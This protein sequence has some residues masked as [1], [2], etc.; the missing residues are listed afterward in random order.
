MSG[1]STTPLPCPTC[2]AAPRVDAGLRWIVACIDCFDAELNDRHVHITSPYGFGQDRDS[3]V[4]R[5]N[6]AVERANTI[7]FL[8]RLT[9]EATGDLC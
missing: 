8:S 3:A 9:P 7:A 2:G 4:E 5:W 1:M 6:S